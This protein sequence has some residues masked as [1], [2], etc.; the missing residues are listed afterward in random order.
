M[1]KMGTREDRNE[2]MKLKKKSKVFKER[3][4]T[5]EEKKSHKRSNVANKY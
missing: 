1:R 2:K 5:K 3:N 4:M